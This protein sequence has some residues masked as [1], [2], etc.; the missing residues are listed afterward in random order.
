MADG[1]AGRGDASGNIGGSEGA[2]EKRSSSLTR[3]LPIE[4]RDVADC[5][6]GDQEDG[7]R[8]LSD[9]SRR[10]R[11]LHAQ[12]ISRR[13]RS[14]LPMTETELRLIAALAI[15]GLRSRPNHGYNTPAASG[16]PR[17]L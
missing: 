3:K 8:Q 1:F 7:A 9:R 5:S 10:L 15:I 13:S 17:A 4:V 6:Q 2:A 11:P 12:S 14:A 16:T